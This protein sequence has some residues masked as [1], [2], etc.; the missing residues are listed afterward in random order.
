MRHRVHTI[1]H[2]HF[3]V[4][5]YAC[6]FFGSSL[7]MRRAQGPLG[8]KIVRCRGRLGRKTTREIRQRTFG[9]EKK[10]SIVEP[11]VQEL[12]TRP[13]LEAAQKLMLFIGFLAHADYS[14]ED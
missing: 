14:L 13:H 5:I 7:R 4:H 9:K 11:E 12:T 6:D 10:K 2:A 1:S 3:R 8:A